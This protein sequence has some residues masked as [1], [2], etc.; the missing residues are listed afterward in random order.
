MNNFLILFIALVATG[1]LVSAVISVSA[2]KAYMSNEFIK[3]ENDDSILRQKFFTLLSYTFSKVMYAAV[4]V[5]I[6]F[7]NAIA[8][9]TVKT[10]LI[11]LGAVSLVVMIVQGDIIKDDV[12]K[13]ALD[14][15]E[16]YSKTVLK[17]SVAEAFVIFALI[18]AFIKLQ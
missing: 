3:R 7:N 17:I 18:Y 4:I 10:A 14:K 16:L 15:P 5:F 12:V 9:E 11:I 8:I 6:V 1:F 2:Y 13:G